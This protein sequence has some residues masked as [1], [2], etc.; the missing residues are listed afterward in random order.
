[1]HRYER[2]LDPVP[3]GARERAT[4]K[5]AVSRRFVALTEAKL[6][7]WF[8]APLGGLDL[9]VVMIDGIAFRKHC[10]L[11]AL[12]IDSD[13]VK[14]PLGLREGT[15]ENAGVAKALLADLIERGLP[16]DTGRCCL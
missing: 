1:M 13:G 14:H 12:G 2:S 6:A 7:A 10:V 3:S 8:S 11:V 16:S 4:S 9:R 5:S 15:T